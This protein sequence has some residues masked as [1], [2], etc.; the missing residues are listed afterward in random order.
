M[1]KKYFKIG[2]VGATGA[3]GQEIIHLLDK[4]HLPI[5]ELRVFASPRSKGKKISFQG[6][7][8]VLKTPSEQAFKGL[9]FILFS[10]G[11]KISLQWI[12]LAVQQ[13]ACVID[14]SS[15]F[16]MDPHVPLVI[17][18]VNPEAA[19]SHQGIIASPNCTATLMLTALFP[20]HK[21]FKIKRIVASTYQAASGAGALAMEE[22]L[23]ESL[24]FFEKKPFQRTVMPH[25]YA[26]NLFLHNAPMNTS[27]FYVG[28]NEEEVKIIEESHKILE[29]SSLRITATCV[30]VPVLRAHSESLN[31]E[32]SLPVRAQE[33]REILRTS[34]GVKLLEDWENN[35]FPMPVDASFEEDIFV[36]RVREDLSQPNTLDLWVVGDQLLKGAALNAVQILEWMITHSWV[37]GCVNSILT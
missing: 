18:E 10:A 5:Q 24:A 7:E 23:Q 31:V 11:K 36:G 12:P 1:S 6:K 27:D 26:F 32:F 4:K 17:P 16:R 22:L 28:Y 8:C 21:K 30:R 2:I 14:N 35:R 34:P 3:V 15:A 19:R 13:G 9:D 20:L 33:A 37:T 29:D 25:P